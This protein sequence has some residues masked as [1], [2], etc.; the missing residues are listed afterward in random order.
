MAVPICPNLVALGFCTAKNCRNKHDGFFCVSCGVVNHTEAAHKAHFYTKRHSRSNLGANDPFYCTIC[1]AV[2]QGKARWDRHV[3]SKGHI[4]AAVK[5]G[6]D[7]NVEPGK[8][9]VPVEGQVFCPV[10]RKYIPQPSWDRHASMRSHKSKVDFTHVRQALDNAAK[11]KHGITVSH[12]PSVDFGT[13]DPD[14]AKQGIQ[15]VLV[16]KTSEP[17]ADVTLAAAR[18]TSASTNRQSP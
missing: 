12:Y 15:V 18:L 11:D 17:D 10:C 8:P 6:V 13:V 3:N 16:V 5:Q 7:W 9:G 14:V 2:V 1:K 4:D